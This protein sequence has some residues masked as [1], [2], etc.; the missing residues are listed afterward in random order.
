MAKAKARVN[1]GLG[2]ENTEVKKM[3]MEELTLQAID[4]IKESGNEGVQPAWLAER[5]GVHKRRIYDL[6]SILRPLGLIETKKDKGG[7]RI[8]WN[9]NGFSQQEPKVNVA[10]FSGKTIRIIP[11]GAITKVRNKGIEVVIE[12]TKPGIEVEEL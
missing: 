1:F 3:K 5:F 11:K 4:L 6:I 12:A 2:E 9:P 7:T 10:R 8:F